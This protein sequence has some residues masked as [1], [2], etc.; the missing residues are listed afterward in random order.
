MNSAGSNSHNIVNNVGIF[1]DIVVVNN[2]LR[3]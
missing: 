2:D 1:N 3:E